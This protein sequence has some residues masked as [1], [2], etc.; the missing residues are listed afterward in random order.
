MFSKDLI[1]KSVYFFPFLLITGPFLPD[2][3]LVIISIFLICSQGIIKKCFDKY[4]YFFLSFFC[5]LV[6]SAIL[7][8]NI[9]HSLKT[10]L[11]YIR[12]LFILVVFLLLSK[13]DPKFD[14]NMLLITSVCLLLIFLFFV[15]QKLEFDFMYLNNQIS[16]GRYS[17]P[18]GEDLKMG[19]FS[20]KIFMLFTFFSFYQNKINKYFYLLIYFTTFVLIFYSGERS[21]LGLFLLFSLII[22]IL[23]KKIFL[24]LSLINILIIFSIMFFKPLELQKKRLFNQTL[25]Q[26]T[27]EKTIFF[28]RQHTGHYLSASEIFKDNKVFGSGPNSFRI[29]CK[30]FEKKIEYSCS[31]HPH[32]IFFQFLSE[33]GL[34]GILFLIM[35]YFTIFN[36]FIK[37]N[38]KRM[39]LATIIVFFNFFPF[40][41]YGNF[42]NNWSSI[43]I[44]LG[45]IPYLILKSKNKFNEIRY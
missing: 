27:D 6:I 10:V 35:F 33:L 39:K 1:Y 34:I 15:F 13:I 41:P 12:F 24:I 14:S 45:L 37:N 2:L 23:N 40:L 22:I 11:P 9:L 25:N 20:L 16:E 4:I 3:L 36:D 30:E 32:N 7:S 5:Y 19:G 29:A 21:S 28:S 38:D 31:S 8:E 44:Y 17:G 26:I 43:I 18:F 42:F